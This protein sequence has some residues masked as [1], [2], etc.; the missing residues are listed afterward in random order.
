MYSF[1]S[2]QDEIYLNTNPCSL[3][4]YGN[5]IHLS[6]AT[7]RGFEGSDGKC[8]DDYSK[9]G[10]GFSRNTKWVLALESVPGVAQHVETAS[11]DGNRCG[12]PSGLG[13]PRNAARIARTFRQ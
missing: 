3:D 8:F 11:N 2:K 10:D 6:S 1:P 5:N 12:L 9:F 4:L 7:G 13:P